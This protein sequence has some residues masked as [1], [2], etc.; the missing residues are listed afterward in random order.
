MLVTSKK[1]KVY[2]WRFKKLKGLP[3]KTKKHKD[4]LRKP[5]KNRGEVVKKIGKMNAFDILH[6]ISVFNFKNKL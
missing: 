4:T 3:R 6:E 5:Q 1:V 2:L